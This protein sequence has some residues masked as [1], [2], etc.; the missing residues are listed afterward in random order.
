MWHRIRRIARHRWLDED[1]TRKAIP[2]QLAERL[3]ARVA[4]S[5]RRH[6]GEIRIYVEAG[7]P[8]SY[9]WRDAGVRERAVAMFGKLRV[10]DTEHNNGVLIY[11]LLAEHAIEIV[12]DR[13]LARRI[14]PGHWHA[15]VQHMREAFRAGRF[16][17]GLTQALEEVS[18][19]LVEHFPLQPG[20]ANPNE[21]PDP[22]ALG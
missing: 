19:L 14:E 5:E 3:A 20:Q 11:L 17:D 10:W 8:L 21:L 2:P 15:I 4:A 9:L 6:S 7:L 16:E 13:G 1:D 12:A 22:P 18:A